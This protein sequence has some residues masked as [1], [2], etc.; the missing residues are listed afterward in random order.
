MSQETAKMRFI[1]THP[2]VAALVALVLLTLVG[3]AAYAVVGEVW[4]STDPDQ[5]PSE[6]EKDVQS[7][8]QAAGVPA[9]VHADRHHVAIDSSGITA[10]SAL[11]RHFSVPPLHFSVRG[12][13]V[14]AE[15]HREFTVRI[16][17]E[18][19]TAEVPRNPDAAQIQAVNTV[20]LSSELTDVIWGDYDSNDDRA[21]A[22]TKVFAAHGFTVT[23]TIDDSGITAHMQVKC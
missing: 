6:I 13:R 4:V 14:L 11:P 12:K 16:T 9:T 15:E 23:V 5:A 18:G 20:G 21:A 8:L 19:E 7:Q 10:G 17:C 3:S 1:K 2:A 22:I